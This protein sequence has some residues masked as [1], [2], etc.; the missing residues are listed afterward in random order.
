MDCLVLKCFID[1]FDAGGHCW[2]SLKLCFCPR[3]VPLNCL[4]W[5]LVTFLFSELSSPT[6]FSPSVMAASMSASGIGYG[7]SALVGRLFA[8][9]TKITSCWWPEFTAIRQFLFTCKSPSNQM[10]ELGCILL[11]DAYIHFQFGG[12]NQKEGLS[13][14]FEKSCCGDK[15]KCAVCL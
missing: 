13:I 3:H 11:I 14:F 9:M 1:Y 2:A 10:I 6:S 15:L 8:L 7:R 5:H 12:T 4:N